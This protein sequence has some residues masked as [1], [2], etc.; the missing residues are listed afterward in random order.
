MSET[1]AARSP[2]GKHDPLVAE[3]GETFFCALIS[4][5]LDDLGQTRQTMP[6]HIRPLDDTRILVGRART[7]LY[8]DVYAPPRPDE[9]HYELEIRLVDD[10]KPGDVAVA[11]CG[12]TGRIAPWGGLLSTAA[13]MRGA[14]GALMD[15]MVR[16]IKDI[17]QMGFPVFAA[18]IAPLDSAGRGKVIEIDVPVECGGVLVHP[19]DIIFGDADGCAVIPRQIENEVLEAG[20]D[21]L[22]REN[23]TRKALLDG[24]LLADVYDEFGVL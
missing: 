19:G 21:K 20:R 1:L 14:T 16:D 13:T 11:S 3:I 18:G 7:M 10:L 23:S 5:V 22:A 17:R 4:D 6:P 12:A 9:N 2:D 8:A 15:G 24:R